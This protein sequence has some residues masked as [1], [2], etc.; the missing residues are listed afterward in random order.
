MTETKR[1]VSTEFKVFDISTIKGLKAAERYQR[2]LY[3]IFDQVIVTPHGLS[4]VH[5]LG[6]RNK[7][8]KVSQ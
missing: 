5:I 2:R 1:L 8:L 4:T 6:R 7:A 3:N